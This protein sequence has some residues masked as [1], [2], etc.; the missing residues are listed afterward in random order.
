MQQMLPLSPCCY[1]SPGWSKCWGHGCP[2]KASQSGANHSLSAVWRKGQ[3]M[4]KLVLSVLA[5]AALAT[6][7]PAADLKVVTK[8]PPPPQPSPWDV[9]FGATLTSDYIFRG[10]TQSNHRPS[11]WAYFEPRYII[12]KDLQL[13]VGVGGESISFPN[14]AAAEID[15]STPASSRLSVRSPSISAP[16]TTGIRVGS[17]STAAPPRFSAWTVWP[18]VICR[19]ISTSSSVT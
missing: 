19:S 9:A 3:T 18:T 2:G 17:A 13:Y 11:V 15:F 6:P 5:V 7:T 12:N 10:I 1:L 8:A 4:K 14:R 16:G